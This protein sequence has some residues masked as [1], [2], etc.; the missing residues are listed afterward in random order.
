LHY[1]GPV[2]PWNKEYDTE[3]SGIFGPWWDVWHQ[4]FPGRSISDVIY[5]GTEIPYIEHKETQ[6]EEKP[7]TKDEHI[8]HD[9]EN[10]EETTVG[11]EQPFEP[12][13]LVKPENYQL[14]DSAVIETTDSA[15]DATRE[16]PPTTTTAK[17]FTELEHG[18]HEF[19]NT[20]DVPEQTEV[21]SNEPEERTVEDFNYPGIQFNEYVKPERVFDSGEDYYPVHKLQPVEKIPLE[22]DA[23]T[24]EHVTLVAQVNT[25]NEQLA[26][27]GIIE[28]DEFEQIYDENEEDEEEE[29]D[30]IELEEEETYDT[31]ESQVP[32]LFPWEFRPGHR[33]ER[34]FD[35]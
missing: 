29:E 16:A 34:T 24:N 35:T 15:W 6:P 10:H 17:D 19:T 5:G 12:S 25:V 30:V 23:S 20:W 2:K 14:F 18:V 4:H 21:S 26:K 1:I 13:D 3:K 32:K 28:N 22:E 11:E 31:Y 7:E 33:P 9:S 8:D 27:L